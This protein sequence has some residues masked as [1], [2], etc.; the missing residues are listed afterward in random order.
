MVLVFPRQELGIRRAR[1][2]DR[3]PRLID[4]AFCHQAKRQHVIRP[5]R[6]RVSIFQGATNQVLANESIQKRTVKVR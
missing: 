6:D 1:V 3:A 5:L 2:A 4:I